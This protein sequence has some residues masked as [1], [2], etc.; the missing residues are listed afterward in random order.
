M[1]KI[2]LIL[3]ILATVIIYFSCAKNVREPLSQ[4]PLVTRMV[5]DVD[6]QAYFSLIADQIKQ[7]AV[8]YTKDLLNPSRIKPTNAD[9]EAEA[10][11]VV[12]THLDETKHI[13]E[14]GM[15]IRK[16]YNLDKLN[17]MDVRVLFDKVLDEF[18][19][20]PKKHAVSRRN[21][22]DVASVEQENNGSMN[23]YAFYQQQPETTSC[24]QYYL[25]TFYTDDPSNILTATPLF[26]TCTEVYH[27]YQTGSSNFPFDTPDFG[28]APSDPADS[29]GLLKKL[30]YC[31]DDFLTRMKRCDR[32][33]DINAG[34][35]TAG[36]VLGGGLA[37]LVTDGAAI[38]YSPQ[39]VA[40]YTAALAAITATLY[41]CKKDAGE[42]HQTCV[43]R[44]N[45]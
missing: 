32:N 27:P 22:K 36:F 34:L 5:K 26:Q 14:M 29:T 39:A 15:T 44:A 20:S 16:R 43:I 28:G 40:G 11:K 45:N 17:E 6:V 13:M 2:F 10:T 30:Q 19:K 8:P 41:L 21:P 7:I 31:H 25:I 42:D 35:L 3:T 24:V 12:T 37:L 23:Y 1:K 18:A 33:A 38:T 9:F 4:D